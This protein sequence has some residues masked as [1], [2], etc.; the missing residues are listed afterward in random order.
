MLVECFNKTASRENRTNSCCVHSTGRLH[1][2]TKI[3]L[4]EFFVASLIE[5][6]VIL[7]NIPLPCFMVRK[8]PILIVAATLLAQTHVFS[9]LEGKPRRI[10]DTPIKIRLN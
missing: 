2:G 10:V 8:A 4:Y 5:V 1:K 6:H 3:S 9:A 7:A